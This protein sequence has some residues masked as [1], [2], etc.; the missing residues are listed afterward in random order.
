MDVSPK[1]IR[2]GCS[3]KRIVIHVEGSFS[4]SS[5]LYGWLCKGR[6]MLC[7]YTLYLLKYYRKKIIT[8]FKY[9]DITA[10]LFSR[11][12]ISNGIPLMMAET[13]F[14]RRKWIRFI[15]NEDE[16]KKTRKLY[17]RDLSSD[18][19]AIEDQRVWHVMSRRWEKIIRIGK[20]CLFILWRK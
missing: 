20:P 8:R 19:S 4:F 18:I 9:L 7:V 6:E 1:R 16:L 11:G 3:K 14:F 17:K 5:L 10:S 15:Y 2:N 13:K 12:N